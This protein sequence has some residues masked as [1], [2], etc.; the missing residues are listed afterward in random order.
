MGSLTLVQ[1]VNTAQTPICGITKTPVTAVGDEAFFM[2]SQLRVSLHV[3][4]GNSVFEIMVAGFHADQ[5][6][7]MKTMKKTLA[8]DAVAKL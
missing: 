5:V 4:K 7:Q 3:R 6:E 2:V 1:R 8:Q